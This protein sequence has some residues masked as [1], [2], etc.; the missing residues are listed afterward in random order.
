VGAIRGEVKKPHVIDPD[1]CI[2]CGS[3]QEICRFNAIKCHH[4]EI[5]LFSVKEKRKSFSERTNLKPPEGG[6]LNFFIP[7]ILYIK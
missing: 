7:L 3:C 2:K 5:E 1:K 4:P 6:F